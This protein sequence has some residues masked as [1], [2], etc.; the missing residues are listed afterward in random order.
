MTA[1]TSR[2]RSRLVH[3]RSQLTALRS[4]LDR[5]R[6]N[7][8]AFQT[9]TGSRLDGLRPT[10]NESGRQES[11][12]PRKPHG[13]RVHVS[14]PGRNRGILSTKEIARFVQVSRRPDAD[15]TRA[16]TRVRDD[17][18]LP[19]W[20]K[21]EVDTEEASTLN[22]LRRL[23]NRE[24]LCAGGSAVTEGDVDIVGFVTQT[25]SRP[26]YRPA[27]PAITHDSRG[28]ASAPP[29]LR[30]RRRDGPW[31]RTW[32]AGLRSRSPAGDWSSMSGRS[33]TGRPLHRANV[34]AIRPG[35]DVERIDALRRGRD[36]GDRLR[37]PR[38]DRPA[39]TQCGRPP[40]PQLEN[41]YSLGSV[42][43]LESQGE[44]ART[45][46]SPG[47]DDSATTRARS[48]AMALA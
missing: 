35:V 23:L 30:P 29:D 34:Q 2:R 26:I 14:L 37:R 27:S 25:I 41:V 28:D 12:P 22:L 1:A 42:A 24:R 45:R 3:K 36:H 43:R 4:C 20:D 5:E 48:R 47:P 10:F 7:F 9:R 31:P 15:E 46:R 19:D 39:A 17:V 38:S 16:I 6:L 13:R 32:A 33:P 18:Y 44:A 8:T 11:Q 40:R 21:P